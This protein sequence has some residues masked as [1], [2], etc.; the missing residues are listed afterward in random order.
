[1]KELECVIGPCLETF[2]NNPLGLS[3]LVIFGLVAAFSVY[4][5]VKK[6]SIR[7]RILW[8]YPLIFSVLFVITYFAFS[9]M[10]HEAL[11]FCT[12]HAIMY[13][14]PAAILGS[15]L[16]GYILLPNIYLAIHR[17][18][19]SETLGDTLPMKVPVYIADSGKPFAFSY[20]GLRKW[21]V[22]SQGMIDIMTENELNAVLLHE[23][24]HLSGNS[25]FYK[26]SSWVYSKIPL[27]RAFL[28]GVVL[29]DEEEKMADRFAIREQ[30]T[31][32][33][34]NVAKKKIRNYFS[35]QHSAR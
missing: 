14:I 19:R 18:V 2:V 22:V 8:S 25:S 31:S 26:T 7:S 9:M 16:F 6:E 29:E 27:L 28:D 17:V 5:I 13:S 20:G 10:C 33:Y 34:V 32:R 15:I 3:S 4:M 24:G 1:M 21:I 12:E 30:G 11:P 35:E 23:Y